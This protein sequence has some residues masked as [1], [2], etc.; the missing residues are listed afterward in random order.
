METHLYISYAATPSLPF[1]MR[2]YG[3]FVAIL[4]L[5]FSPSANLQEN[6]LVVWRSRRKRANTRSCMQRRVQRRHRNFICMS[7]AY[8]YMV[9]QTFC[10]IDDA[11]IL[12]CS[13]SGAPL[14]IEIFSPMSLLHIHLALAHR[15]HC[16][17]FI[18]VA[19]MLCCAT[20][21]SDMSRS[22]T[23]AWISNSKSKRLVLLEDV[24]R[25]GYLWSTLS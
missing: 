23:K 16:N 24:T 22:V 9:R 20:T 10:S 3:T 11:T 14:K 1:C 18:H 17:S 6:P 13:E 5:P 19:Y 7:Y 21:D 25:G 2:R 15:A 8:V 4:S 12:N